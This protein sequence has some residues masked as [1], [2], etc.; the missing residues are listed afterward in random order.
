MQNYDRNDYAKLQN[1][2]SDKYLS[3]RIKPQI[4]F[5]TWT[6]LLHIYKTSRNG[7]VYRKREI[8]RCLLSCLILDCAWNVFHFAKTRRI[9]KGNCGFYL[10]LLDI[11]T[12]S[13]TSL[14]DWIFIENLDKFPRIRT[15]I[16]GECNYTS[17]RLTRFRCVSLFTIMSQT[18]YYMLSKSLSLIIK[19]ITN[20][21]L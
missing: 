7:H 8:T 5:Y 9:S 16:Y 4:N 11:E 13:R 19:F 10:V 21:N 1:S 17:T 20:F 14:S 3:N 6:R 18:I 15:L 2:R 12:L